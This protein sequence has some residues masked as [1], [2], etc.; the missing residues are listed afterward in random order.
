M[1]APRP[2]I[3]PY[4]D[5]AL[6]ESAV[7]CRACGRDLVPVLPLLRRLDALEARCAAFEEAAAARPPALAG[8][9]VAA[10]AAAPV[11]FAPD[12]PAPRRYWV[13]PAGFAA[14][15][16]AWAA[17]VLW[18]DLPLSVLRVLSIALPFATGVAYF[19]RRPRLRWFDALAA[20]V[21]AVASVGAMNAWLGVVDDAPIAPQDAAAWRES[22]YYALSIGASMLSG[23]LLGTLRAALDA[24][25][26]ASLPRLRDM[27][28]SFNRNLPMDTIKA[29]ELTILLAGTVISAGAGLVAG[30][31]GLAR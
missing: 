28:L 18:L 29:V 14:L 24:R 27:L 25:G 26:L 12:P 2:L 21:L 13:L 31:M 9:A 17:V 16:G 15:L 4:C 19:G 3:C 11:P 7:S 10:D 8:P 23:M 5:A 30:L 6:S 1:S 22:V 20:A